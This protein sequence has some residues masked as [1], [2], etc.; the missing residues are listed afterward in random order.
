[1]LHVALSLLYLPDSKNKMGIYLKI[2]VF[3]GVTPFWLESTDVSEEPVI[4]IV[5]VKEAA[6]SICSDN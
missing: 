3:C 6:G 1:M 4:L 5:R 2:A